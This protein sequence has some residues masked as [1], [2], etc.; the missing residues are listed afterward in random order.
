MEE[1]LLYSVKTTRCR[2]GLEVV[3]REVDKVDFVGHPGRGG[4]RLGG[5]KG[6][7]IPREGKTLQR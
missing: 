7:S 5:Q 3:V 2:N 1:E 6:E 4:E